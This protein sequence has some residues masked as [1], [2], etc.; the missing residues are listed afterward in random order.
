MLRAIDLCCGGGGWACAARGL[1]IDIVLAVDHWDR[2]CQT[3]QHNHQD[4]EVWQRELSDPEVCREVTEYARERDVQLV[5]GGIPCEWLSCMR[6]A[7]LG[8]APSEEEIA[9][10]RR[11]L[12]AILGGDG[13]PGGIIRDINPRWWCLEDVIGLRRELPIFTPHV[14]LDA[15][16]W[17]PQRRKRLFVG[18]FPRPIPPGDDRLLAD[19]LRPGPHRISVG[20]QRR[21]LTRHTG[22][23]A[24]RAYKAEAARKCPTVLARSTRCDGETILYDPEIAGA[25]RQIEWQEWAA[26]Q[27]F[28]DDYVFVGSQTDT[29][30]MVGRAVQIDLGRAILSGI[31]RE[32]L[33]LHHGGCHV[34]ADAQE[35]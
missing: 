4:T 13:V 14:V 16:G 35:G 31:A 15:A 23:G 2:A 19:V 3:Y 22:F 10:E 12:H 21:E 1:P 7:G 5:L 30:Q 26:A 20:G 8:N 11:L 25:R 18:R 33:S 29:M 9:T 27:G 17:S 32:Y 6:R 28:P 34:S 24:G